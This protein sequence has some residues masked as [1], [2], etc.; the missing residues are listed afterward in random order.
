M[1]DTYLTHYFQ[2]IHTQKTDVNP[3]YYGCDV[4]K[5]ASHNDNIVHIGARHFD[6]SETK[7]DIILV[8]YLLSVFSKI[9]NIS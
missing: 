6:Q 3:K 7:E 5:Y 4:G 9:I 2:A 8:T 1:R